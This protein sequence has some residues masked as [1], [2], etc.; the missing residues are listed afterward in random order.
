MEDTPA[1]FAP[2]AAPIAAPIVNPPPKKHKAGPGRPKGTTGIGLRTKRTYDPKE[3]AENVALSISQGRSLRNS[4]YMKEAT[5]EDRRQI[6]RVVGETVEAF[7]ERVALNLREIADLATQR[8]KEKLEADQFK[9]GE[10]GFILSVAHDKRLS[11][12][13]SRALQMSSVNIQVNNFGPAPKEALLG[14]LDGLSSI[15]PASPAA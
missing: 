2:V 15:K 7:N 10:L 4:P 9:P 11:L 8:I 14:E 6:A 1:P 5:E 13:G 12:D 3:L